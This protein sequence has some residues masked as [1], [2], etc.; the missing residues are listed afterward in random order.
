MLGSKPQKRNVIPKGNKLPN[1]KRALPE[2]DLPDPIRS[3]ALSS[4]VTVSPIWKSHQN[5]AGHSE[6]VAVFLLLTCC[7]SQMLDLAKDALGKQ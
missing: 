2:A 5:L 3:E 7:P 4:P 6:V 1:Y